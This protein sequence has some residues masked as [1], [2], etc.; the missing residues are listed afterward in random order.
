MSKTNG[1][2]A[3]AGVVALAVMAV[4]CG[5]PLLI[6]ALAVGAP[7]ALVLR[8][9][10]WLA[11]AAS[12]GVALVGVAVWRRRRAASCDTRDGQRDAWRRKAS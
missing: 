4:C 5:A 9:L 3:I 2:G 8:G 1:D 7:A 12:V 10:P 11:A 6:G